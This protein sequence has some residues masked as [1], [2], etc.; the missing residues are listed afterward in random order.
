[1]DPLRYEVEWVADDALLRLSEPTRD[2][3]RS[4]AAALAEHYNEPVN[5]ALMTNSAD[6]SAD[7]VVALYEEMWA[8]GGRPFFLYRD[9]AHLGDCDFRGLQGDHAEFAILVG[10]RGAQAKGLGTRFTLMAHALA[11]GPLGLERVFISVRPENAGSLRMFQKVGYTIDESAGARAYAE[12]ADDVCLSI[13]RSDF[14]RTHA[15]MLAKL[16]IRPRSVTGR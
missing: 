14:S 4:H 15:A 1:M 13:G 12:A 16:E 3:L 9:G 11:F 5:R 7:D 6:H 2:E 8:A 10:P